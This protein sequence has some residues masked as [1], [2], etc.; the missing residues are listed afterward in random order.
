MKKFNLR[1]I[2][3]LLMVSLI[4]TACGDKEAGMV[5]K[6][7]LSEMEMAGDTLNYGDLELMGMEEGYID[8]QEDGNVE[9]VVFGETAKVEVDEKNSTMK[10]DGDTIS[11]VLSGDNIVLTQDGMEITFVLED[12]PSWE[13]IKGEESSVMEGLGEILGGGDTEGGTETNFYGKYYGAQLTEMGET[14]GRED[15]DMIGGEGGTYVDLKETGDSELSLFG[16]S[17][18]LNVDHTTQTITIEGL[19]IQEFSVI[20]DTLTIAVEGMEMI[21]IK[22]GSPDWDNF[23]SIENSKVE[24]ETSETESRGFRQSPSSG[25]RTRVTETLVNPSEWYGTMTISGYTG[26]YESMDGETE[27]WGRIGEDATGPYFEIYAGEPYEF[28]VVS[29]YIELHDYTFFPII[30]PDYTWMFNTTLKEEDETWYTPTLSS[31][32]LS[33]TYDFNYNGESFTMEYSMMQVDGASVR[34]PFNMASSSEE[35]IVEETTVEE[36]TV[37]ETQAVV[38]E[39]VYTRDE[40]KELYDGFDYTMKS[41]EDLVA[42]YGGVEPVVDS[43]GETLTYYRYWASDDSTAYVQYAIG[44]RDGIIVIQGQASYNLVPYTW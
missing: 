18:I 31:G 19:E 1:N 25:E 17:T 20:G 4:L 24:A 40:L 34:D 29:Y 23:S 12:S 43:V 9:F 2:W 14:I 11:Y 5:G 8:F 33:A 35:T 15:I 28:I 16:D 42:H 13:S 26:P 39:A 32:V 22:D 30:V 37:A 21:F 44:E 27:I 6:Y 3:M 36:T 41:Y 38:S 10:V 7:L